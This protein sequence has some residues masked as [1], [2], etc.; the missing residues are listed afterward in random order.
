MKHTFTVLQCP[1]CLAWFDEDVADSAYATREVGESSS[2]AGASVPGPAGVDGRPGR[3]DG[4]HH[5][6]GFPRLEGE[7][8]PLEQ[9]SAGPAKEKPA[10]S[11]EAPPSDGTARVSAIDVFLAQL[12]R[13]KKESRKWQ[14]NSRGK[15]PSGRRRL[16]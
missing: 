7:Q 4:Y 9:A 10:N 12:I 14:G 16:R 1:H 2:E 6:G 15:P 8:L 3:P 13:Q 11:P 5:E